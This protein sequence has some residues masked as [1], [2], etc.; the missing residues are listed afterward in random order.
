MQSQIPRPGYGLDRDDVPPQPGQP[1]GQVPG[2][3]PPLIPESDPVLPPE[4]SENDDVVTPP[5]SDA[6]DDPDVVEP[7]IDGPTDGDA[8]VI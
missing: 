8:P 6:G 1:P 4:V 3:I 2:Q 5:V 7:G